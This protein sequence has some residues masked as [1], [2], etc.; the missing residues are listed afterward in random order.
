MRLPHFRLE[1][2]LEERELVG[3][4]KSWERLHEKRMP[5]VKEKSVYLN[6]GG[7]G[8]WRGTRVR[9]VRREKKRQK[10]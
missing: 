5:Q 8:M 1:E 2:R 10:T 6:N 7:S 3:L 9:G 4:L